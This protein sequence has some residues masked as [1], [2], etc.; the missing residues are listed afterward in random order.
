MD[1]RGGGGDGD[2]LTCKL[3]F[4]PSP[5]VVVGSFIQLGQ[6]EEEEEEVFAI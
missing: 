2:L 5:V 6:E 4:L 1:A 3:S